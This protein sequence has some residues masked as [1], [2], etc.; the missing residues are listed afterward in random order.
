VKQEIVIQDISRLKHSSTE[1]GKQVRG[2]GSLAYVLKERSFVSADEC[3]GI[4]A[5]GAIKY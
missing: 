4:K 3:G 1:G 2:D 5:D